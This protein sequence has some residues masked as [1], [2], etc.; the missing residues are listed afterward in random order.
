MVLRLI[1]LLLICVVFTT[2]CYKYE[3]PEAPEP[4][5]PPKTQNGENIIGFLL[6]GK[7]WKPGGNAF[8]SFKRL[9]RA[10]YDDRGFQIYAEKIDSENKAVNEFEIM[11]SDTNIQEGIYI[12]DEWPQSESIARFYFHNPKDTCEYF[13]SNSFGGQINITK[14]DTANKIIAGTFEIK[15]INGKCQDIHITEGRFDFKYPF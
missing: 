6:N 10:T 11:I 5:L 15:L 8:L 12:I 14:L 3:I 13:S 1:F 2:S 4:V 7:V 9:L